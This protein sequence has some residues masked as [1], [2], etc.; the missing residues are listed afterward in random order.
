MGVYNAV[1]MTYKKG[2]L[3]K[4]FDEEQKKQ[5]VDSTIDDGSSRATEF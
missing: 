3:K 4:I 5:Y 1:V 2:L